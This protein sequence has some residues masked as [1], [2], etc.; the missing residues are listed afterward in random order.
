MDDLDVS[1]I[2]RCDIHSVYINKA[3]TFCCAIFEMAR[4][5]ATYAPWHSVKIL[6][7]VT[8]HECTQNVKLA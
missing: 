1:S 4:V 5:L 3:G 8:L 6:S 2:I 7:A